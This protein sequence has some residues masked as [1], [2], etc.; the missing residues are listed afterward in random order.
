MW[1]S[2]TTE[3]LKEASPAMSKDQIAQQKFGKPYAEL[4][5]AQ[6]F[7]VD[8]EFESVSGRPAERSAFNPATGN[9]EYQRWNPETQTWEWTG[10]IA[11]RPPAGPTV[12]VAAPNQLESSSQFTWNDTPY[13]RTI[14][15]DPKGGRRVVFKNLVTG[16][17]TESLPASTKKA[18]ERKNVSLSSLGTVRTKQGSTATRAGAAE[19][20]LTEG[21][22]R[23]YVPES[24]D[25][26]A[27]NKA[28]IFG[29]GTPQLGFEL[30]TGNLG[31]YE[32]GDTGIEGN[33]DVTGMRTAEIRGGEGMPGFGF[34]PTQIMQAY[35]RVPTGD[36]VKD[37]ALA[38]SLM[39]QRD[40]LLRAG[41]SPTQAQ[42]ILTTPKENYDPW[43]PTSTA[44]Q[45]VSETFPGS[46][47]Y[48]A[49]ARNINPAEVPWMAHGGDMMLD[50]PVMGVGMRDLM[51]GRIDPKFIA[52]EAGLEKVSDMNNG[53]HFT[54][55]HRMPDG[56]MMSGMPMFGEGGS[57]RF[58]NGVWEPVTDPF[59]LTRAQAEN[60]NY[61]S[62]QPAFYP[63]EMAE[64]AGTS[65][66]GSF[67]QY[68]APAPPVGTLAQNAFLNYLDMP[69]AGIL[70][71]ETPYLFRDVPMY[72]EGGDYLFDLGGSN[73]A[74]GG[75]PRP[76]NTQMFTDPWALR[77]AWEQRQRMINAYKWG[78]AGLPQPTPVLGGGAN[79]PPGMYPVSANGGGNTGGG[80]PP[81]PVEQGPASFV[82]N[83]QPQRFQMSEFSGRP[84]EPAFSR[85]R[86]VGGGADTGQVPNLSQPSLLQD[87]IALL[88]A[89]RDAA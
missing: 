16:E 23:A 70:P 42:Q 15:E 29:Q 21:G 10:V 9:Q 75:A 2:T 22:F 54:P 85:Q 79:L 33:I 48:E 31:P 52:G 36:P 56:R 83:P 41:F 88:L 17:E 67:F 20:A 84:E 71:G 81:A 37:T 87:P 7:I 8:D 5:A 43:H 57:A 24:Y 58:V 72:G 77:R 27:P 86:N 69:R 60:R 64:E 38:S 63:S 12:N 73:S 28:D 47:V 30:D 65:P 40:A 68:N 74:G 82:Y 35:M 3:L 39:V 50:E 45:T 51:M 4:T 25:F 62:S 59:M 34:D 14:I 49:K 46:G 78:M 26:N 76:D 55:M 89:L 44:S 32:A 1:R 53:V 6:Q 66:Y 13:L 11:S 80:Y 61:T 19:P 18:K